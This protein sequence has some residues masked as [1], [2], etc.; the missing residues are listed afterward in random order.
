MKTKEQA[1]N[2]IIGNQGKRA[3]IKGVEFAESWIS[4]ENELPELREFSLVKLSDG[5]IMYA[6][7]TVFG[8]WEI[9]WSGGIGKMNLYRP[10]T[11]WRP[12]TR[13]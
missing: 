5:T 7:F 8:N 13:T 3:F 2:E 12:I 10:V 1:V 11:H 4:V 6:K 9:F